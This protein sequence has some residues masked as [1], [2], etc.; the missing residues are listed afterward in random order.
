MDREIDP[1]TIR[2]RRLRTTVVT[3][4]ALALAWFAIATV[5]GM[6][7][8]GV[9]ASELRT[10]KVTRGPVAEVIDATGTVV[11]A[12]ET[13]LSSPI[14]T[15]VVE[16]LAKP[17]AVLK[18]G[19]PI[20][21][22]DTSSSRLAVERLSDRVGQKESER[23][24]LRL[25][26]EKELFELET[27]A[28]QQQLDAEVLDHRLAQ[29]QTLSNEGLLSAEQ[30]RQTE[31]EAKKAT[32]S[33]KQSV[34]QID[35]A[36]KTGDARVH[37]I[38]LELRIL[39]NE[40]DQAE[41]ELELATAKAETA[42]ILTWIVDEPGVTLQRG[43]VFARIADQS[44]WR[45]EAS[46]SDIHASRLSPGMPVEIRLARE[47]LSGTISSVNPAIENGSARFEVR[48]DEPSHPGLRNS[49]RVEV[50]VIAGEQADVLKVTRGP[51]AT[52][53]RREQVFV[54]HGNEGER[55][56]VEIGAFGRDELQILSGLSEG[57]EI[58]ISNTSEFRHAGRV[59]ITGKD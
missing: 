15:R 30:L 55:R 42:G 13:V 14:E 20:L 54:V 22:L 37:A 1:A 2:N 39:R 4:A 31:A 6:L 48:L 33:W 34:R 58:I 51:F 17:G 44:S 25:T 40:L 45:V 9:A 3:I 18:P 56:E 23:T 36:R 19:D 12:A 28:E 41:R 49:L 7:R 46:T 5:F 10:A 38:D 27:Q 29:Q 52:G 24:Q 32:L 59:R 57:D 35:N 43:Q 11:P 47:V 21:R 50:T 8:P 53:A 26:V 16:I